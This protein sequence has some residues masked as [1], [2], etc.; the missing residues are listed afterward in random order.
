MRIINSF[1]KSNNLIFTE[2]HTMNDFFN[3]LFHYL[4]KEEILL[5]KPEFLFQVQSHPNYPSLLAI[6]DTLAFFNIDNAAIRVEFAE[7]DDMP[8]RFITLLSEHLSIPHLYFIEKK[9]SSYFATKDKK[10]VEITKASLESRWNNVVLLAERSEEERIIKNKKQQWHWFLSSLCL[11][12]FVTIV[13]LFAGGLRTYSFFI[14]PTIGLL[15]SI[16]AIKD[17]FGAKSKLINSFC[18]ITASTSCDS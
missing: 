9:D 10:T 16:A 4:E 2:Q 3:F 11:V 13:F 14:F 18:N 5:D 15:F 12:L 1:D 6:S 8:D 7:I 17:L